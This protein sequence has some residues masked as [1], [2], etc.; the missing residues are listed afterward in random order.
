MA[1]HDRVEGAAKTMGGN[2]KEVAGK[3]TGDEKMKAEGRADQAEGKV[4][5]AVGGMKDTVRDHK[6]D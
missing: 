5:N 3:V 6:H 2:M 1:D 4:Q